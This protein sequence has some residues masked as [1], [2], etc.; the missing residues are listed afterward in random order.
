MNHKTR[1]T[2]PGFY[3]DPQTDRYYRKT[4]ELQGKVETE[5]LN[6]T[7]ERK[8]TPNI[9]EQLKRRESSRLHR[10]SCAETCHCFAHYSPTSQAKQEKLESRSFL[11]RFFDFDTWLNSGVRV[12]TVSTDP[13][14]FGVTQI[15][16]DGYRGV[17][18]EKFFFVDYGSLQIEFARHLP[19]TEPSTLLLCRNREYQGFIIVNNKTNSGANWICQRKSK[20]C[21]CLQVNRKS[22]STANILLASGHAGGLVRVESIASER[23]VDTCHSWK[24]HKC[25]DIVTLDF[26]DSHCLVAASRSGQGTILDSRQKLACHSFSLN[27]IQQ[28]TPRASPLS[29]KAIQG[30][31]AVLFGLVSNRLELW[32]WRKLCHKMV[33]YE[34]HRMDYFP[35][36]ISVSSC[37]DLVTCGSS[38]TQIRIWDLKKGGLPIFKKTCP[39]STNASPICCSFLSGHPPVGILFSTLSCIGALQH[40]CFS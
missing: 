2:L 30:L 17:Q 35:L 4:R 22:Y 20:P 39:Y 12:C 18:F 29:C 32:D 33:S 21:F 3:Y 31:S 13:G 27:P 34:D 16:Y 14:A 36:P 24:M 7:K 8:N 1:P 15:H 5:N 11:P 23:S 28:E 38:D 25:S 10:L 37:L 40:E 26:I 9:L 19:T 6:Y